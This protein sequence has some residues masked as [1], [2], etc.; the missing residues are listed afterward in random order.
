MV[1]LLVVSSGCRRDDQIKTY[2]VSKEPE[3]PVQPTAAD[4]PMPAADIPVAS[5]PIHWT[6]PPT[7]QQLAPDGVR[8]GKFAVAGPG[9][10]KADVGIFSFPGTVGTELQNVNRWRGELK[11]PS[12]EE[13][14][15]SSEPINIDGVNGKLYDIAGTKDRT[16]VATL[17]RDGAMWFF[18]MRGPQEIVVTA[19]P[20][21]LDL[22]KSVHFGAANVE[23]TT[24]S[25]DN[26]QWAVPTSWKETQPG[27]MVFRS[28]SAGDEK[29]KGKSAAISISFFSGD[30]GGTLANVN[31]WRGQLGLPAVEE[32]GLSTVTQTLDSAGGN[33]T[34]VDFTGTDA[35][36][37]QPARLVAAIV[38]HGANTWFYKL[39]GDGS[40]VEKEKDNFVKFVQTAHYP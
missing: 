20:A 14:E 8:I 21:F 11:L 37:G 4:S 17:P 26:P 25:A 1:G 40:V 24:P 9:D 19:K 32:S 16:V 36:T 12:I 23:A 13:N 38:P 5:A 7:W 18:K 2:T 28:F 39:M 30:V 15:I 22:L 29:E 34:L 3:A 27:P 31:R 35:K 33:A 10:S 6:T